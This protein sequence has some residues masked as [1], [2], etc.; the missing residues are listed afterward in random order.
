MNNMEIKTNITVIIPVHELS[1]KTEKSFLNAIKSVEYQYI[2]PDEVIIV[3]PKNSEASKKLKSFDLGKL[4][5]KILEHTDKTD[6][7]TQVNIGVK[8]SKTEWFSILEYDDEYA[9]IW[10]KNVLKYIDAYHEKLS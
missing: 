9:K 6:F 8:E 4:N 7:S 10:F 2:K 5:V 1:E 3:T